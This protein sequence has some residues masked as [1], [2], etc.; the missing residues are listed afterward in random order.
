MANI[1]DLEERMMEYVDRARSARFTNLEKDNA[2]NTAIDWFFYDRYDN[3]KQRK[4][5]SFE[6]IQRVRDDLRTLIKT[7]PLAPSGNIVSYPSDYRHELSFDIIVNGNQVSCRK[8]SY[9]EYRIIYSNSFE[10]PTTQYPVNY[11]DQNGI[12][13]DFGGVG[14]F[15]SSV[16]S[17]LIHPAKVFV[18]NTNISAGPSVLTIGQTYYVNSGSVTVNSVTYNQGQDFVATVTAMTG[19]GTVINIVNPNLPQHT[20]EELAKYGAQVLTGSIS[21]F[22]KSK[23]TEQE[24]N[25]A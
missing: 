7:V 15:T 4:A 22:N 6:F 1:V 23:W 11:E 3:I 13:V 19:T 8:V 2:I 24:A 5:Y 16:L 21:D 12:N 10:T 25:K 14:T 18:S 20:W 17:Y 9:D